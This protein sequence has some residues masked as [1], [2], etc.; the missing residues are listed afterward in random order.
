[1]TETLLWLWLALL[2]WGLGRRVFRWL[3]GGARDMEALY[4]VGLG[5]GFLAVGMIALGFVQGYHAGLVWALLAGL[6][7]FL[8]VRLR[9]ERVSG[10][11]G[12]RKRDIG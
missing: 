4:S 10:V 2:A 12:F 11:A 6:S 9:G 1:M 5:Y 3:F 7:V 8:I